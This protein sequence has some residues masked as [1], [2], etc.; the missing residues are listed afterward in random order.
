MLSFFL[1]Y[2]Q[3][4]VLSIFFCFI[5]DKSKSH[6]INN[7]VLYVDLSIQKLLTINTC[8]ISDTQIK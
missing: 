7:L 4:L 5:I 2:S 6:L 8:F 1:S 3:S